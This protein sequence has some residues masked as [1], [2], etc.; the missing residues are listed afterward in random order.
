M[1]VGTMIIMKA[2]QLLHYHEIFTLLY[3][4]VYIDCS[5]GLSYDAVYLIAAPKRK[6]Q[7]QKKKRQPLVNGNNHDVTTP[8]NSHLP[9]CYQSHRDIPAA[10]DVVSQVQLCTRLH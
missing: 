7:R 10:D 9:V 8:R 4:N 1:G 3:K 5:A 2:Y 6:V